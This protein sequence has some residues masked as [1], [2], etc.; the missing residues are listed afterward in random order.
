[1]KTSG[2][3]PTI[4]LF[5]IGQ[6]G[7]TVCALPSIKAIRDRYAT[8]KLYLVTDKH[9][10]SGFVSSWDILGPTGYFAGVVSYAVGLTGGRRLI[11]LV[12]VITSIRVKRPAV[13][14][15][16]APFPRSRGQVLRDHIFF[17]WLCGIREVHG[18]DQ[19]PQVEPYNLREVAQVECLHEADRLLAVLRRAGLQVPEQGKATFD[20][21][22][23]RGVQQRVDVIW[24]E[25]GLPKDAG[26]VAM[27]PCSKMPSKRWPVER[28][29]SVARS[30]LSSY[31]QSHIV[32]L[33]AK[34][35]RDVCDGISQQLGKRAT[36]LAGR[37]SVLEAAEVL[38]RSRIY[39]GNDTGLM[40]LA[41]A[42]GTKCVVVF[43]A[44]DR[45]G[46]WH[47]Y[48][49]GHV[50]LRYDVPCAGCM[51]QECIEQNMQCLKMISKEDVLAACHS[52]LRSDCV[53]TS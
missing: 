40:H 9:E 19:E 6:L 10:E 53:K 13:L 18:C 47:P 44:R 42:T 50:V 16:L 51:L 26:V 31:P 14:F 11:D 25:V 34:G 3:P 41:A 43:S 2:P 24:S 7:D 17:R 48:G 38:N 15:Y 4:F 37:L 35:E 23:D 5:R 46:K 36:S 12:N 49:E 28:F 39:L 33:G 27:C 22:L 52:L 29:L 21:P 20:L 8:S 30:I 1:M 45:P 32:I